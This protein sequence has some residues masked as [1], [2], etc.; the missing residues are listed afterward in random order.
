M[1]RIKS[2]TCHFL[3]LGI[4]ALTVSCSND[5]PLSEDNESDRNQ[6]RLDAVPL[7][8]EALRS[9][10][11]KVHDEVQSGRFVEVPADHS[12]VTFINQWPDTFDTEL[13]GSFIAAGIAVG[14][15]NNDG[16]PDFFAARRIDGGRL[17]QNLG[18]FQFKDVTED[19]GLDLRGM[20]ATGATFADI[21]NDGRLDLF[22]CGF[23]CLNRM[24]INL[25][26][27]FEEQASQYGLLYRGP[28][29]VMTFSD[30]DRDG[31]LDAYLLTNHSTSDPRPNVA[32]EYDSRGRPIVPPQFAESFFFV[33]HP[34][35]GYVKELAGR[36]DRL[37]RNDG[38]TFV[39]V[40]DEAG[41]GQRPFFGLSATWWDYNDDGW[42]DLYV[43]NDFKGADHLFRNNGTDDKGHVTFTDVSREALPHTPWFSMGSDIADINNDGRMDLLASDMAGTNHYRDKLS[44][45][46][47]SG[48][49]S[50]AWFLNWPTP[51]QYIR[52]CLYLNTGTERFM[53]SAYLCG[54]AKTGWTW[55]VRFA[56]LDQDGWQDVYFTNGMSRD[57]FNGDRLNEAKRIY[58]ESGEK[59][60]Y[61]FWFSTPLYKL[62]NLAFR[63]DG[64]LGFEDVSRKWGLSHL[65]VSTGAATA[66]FDG[67]GDLDLIINGFNEPLKIYR[68]EVADGNCL[69]LYLHGRRSNR[70]GLGAKVTVET[71]DHNGATR[72]QIRY[73]N[74]NQGIMS[75]SEPVVH[76]GV[77]RS[78]VV[79]RLEIAWP[80]GIV[81]EFSD[82]TTG[83]RLDI[84]EPEEETNVGPAR[85][86][87]AAANTTFV[88]SSS[89][90]PDG[91]RHQEIPFDDFRLQPLIPNKYSQLGPGISWGDID[92]DG[93]ED[94]FLGGARGMLATL[95][96]NEHGMLRRSDQRCFLADRQMEDLGSLFFDADGDGDLDL[97]VVSGGTEYRPGHKNLQDRLYLNDGSG[98][99]ESVT[100]NW[101]PKINSS[102][103]CVIGAD[104]D[105][106]GDVDLFVGGRL[107][108][109][110]YPTAPRSYLLV[111]NGKRF[112]EVTEFLAPS[113]AYAG[114]VTSAIWS[115][116]NNDDWIDLLVTY[117][118]GP[119][120]V[121]LNREGKFADIT[122]SC[123][124]ANYRGWYNSI[125]SGDIDNDGDVDYVVGNFGLNAKYD[126]SDETP[127]LLFYGAF[128]DSGTKNIIE[129][130]FE[131]DVCLPHR[132]LGC[133]SGAIPALKEKL[134]T[135]H[136][137]AST[138]LEDIYTT[139]ALE[140]ASRYEINNLESLLLINDSSGDSISFRIQPLPRIAQVSS[141]FG[142]ALTDI[143]GDGNLDLV[144]VQNFYGPQRETGYIDGGVS[145]VLKGDG[146]GHLEPIWPSESGV[147]V[148]G[149]ATSLTIID[150]NGDRKPDLMVGLN[151]DQPAYFENKTVA[152][153]LAL[154]LRGPGSNISSVGTR[155]Y[156]HFDDGRTVACDVNSGGSYLSQS[157]P[158]TFIT[159]STPIKYIVVVWPDGTKESYSAPF[160]TI[161]GRIL[162]GH[163]DT[164]E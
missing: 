12:G 157:S 27:T 138:S 114:M 122:D 66:D 113:L 43:A 68:N 69:K 93:D 30:Y 152:S 90:V 83:R 136:E 38:N 3:F 129:A 17:Y 56:D 1:N 137:F 112:E 142:S 54:L 155:V 124:L 22:I 21:N 78:D 41:V 164:V 147:V 162:I 102:G 96:L 15:I 119:V 153:S 37:Y 26:R 32:T 85:F 107:V 55:T 115:D 116:V 109:G 139:S 39:D 58:N 131:N 10:A 106:D 121:F 7:S 135:F 149:D 51:P 84:T 134:P 24:Y 92:N 60:A 59:A 14:D 50:R 125:S 104:F 86:D 158:E 23:D 89:V 4:V 133:S 98:Q 145:L 79:T 81:Q 8:T 132:G 105:R 73:V 16:L 101:L 117:E 47:M 63:N 29:V 25:G 75:S 91:A 36:F 127:Q 146:T 74:S 126:A 71:S 46:P 151:N 67:D 154:R 40:T 110:Q 120:R 128:D 95:L 61:D 80:S 99:F 77:G 94:C 52:N 130:M 100:D 123:Q 140:Q 62:E 31:D 108:P 45:G 20:W 160:A 44:M 13:P 76:F 48:P 72:Q 53:E 70:Q 82:V 118:W 35:G 5:N 111:N 9:S 34:D 150:V 6:V 87:A 159:A 163:G 156:L 65:G 11:L 88:K 64:Q 143:D 144:I 28:S 103:S 161:E 49:D 18:N 148:A 42:P 57:W 97:Y 19:W 33:S 141:I 2:P